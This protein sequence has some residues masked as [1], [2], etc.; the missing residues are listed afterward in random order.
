MIELNEEQRRQ[1]ENGQAVDVTDDVTDPRTAQ[2]Y[3][4]LR[5]DVYE[6]IRRLLYD[7]SEWTEDER[8]LRLAQSARDNG[9]EEAGM[10]AYDRYDEEACKRCP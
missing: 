6:K 3:V 7:D 1:L 8:R 2:R 10:D 5:K 4:V 9:W